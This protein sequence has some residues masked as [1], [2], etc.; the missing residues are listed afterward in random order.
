MS[1]VANV[2][3]NRTARDNSNVTY[4]CVK[5]LQF[6]SMT[7]P[8][9]PELR[10]G[11][12]PLDPSDWAAWGQAVSIVSQAAQGNHGAHDANQTV[13]SDVMTPTTGDPSIHNTDRQAF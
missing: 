1:S 4:E 7:A 5:R 8:N 9:D 6:S 13:C 11:P 3:L 10:L 2:I 12:D